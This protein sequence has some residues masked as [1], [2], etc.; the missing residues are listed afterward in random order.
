MTF[1][2]ASHVSLPTAA[3]VLGGAG[4]VP[5]VVLAVTACVAAEGVAIVSS[6]AVVTYGAVI[7]SFIGG[8]HWGFASGSVAGGHAPAA[9]RLFTASVVPS[10]VGWVALMLPT[11][12]S[13]AVLGIAF[14][15][16]LPL[17]RWAW[18]RSLTPNWWMRLRLPLSATVATSLFVTC[19][20]T[21][22]RFAS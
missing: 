2:S 17:D 1:E 8:A 9:G 11:P 19:A 3:V 4:A 16:L 5:F 12:W 7:L 20:A 15:A 10:L 6:E 21:L 18:L 13:A 22:L 14:V